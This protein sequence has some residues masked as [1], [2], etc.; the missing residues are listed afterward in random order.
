M[1]EFNNNEYR[2]KK[3]DI[4]D[5]T[6]EVHEEVKAHYESEGVGREYKRPVYD[7]SYNY[8]SANSSNASHGHER[9][10]KIKKPMSRGI[11]ALIIAILCFAS[12][13]GGA[14]VMGYVV[15]P[16]RETTYVTEDLNGNVSTAQAAQ[17]EESSS[18]AQ[19]SVSTAQAS[20][21]DNGANSVVNVAKTCTPGVVGIKTYAEQYVP[22]Q[23]VSENQISYGSGFVISQD[24]YIVTN[25]H[26]ISSGNKITVTL[27]DGTEYD[28]SVV[29]ADDDSDVAV[30]KIDAQGLTAL[31]IGD[32]DTVE[33]GQMVVAIGNPISEKLANTVTVGYVSGL[34]RQVS[35]EKRTYNVIQT[36]A[37]INSGNSG[38]PLVN[39]NG[40][41]IAVN[42]LKS[43]YAGTDG[44]GNLIESDGIGFAIPINYV[45][46]IA[47]QLMEN[48][49]IPKAGIGLTYYAMTAE[50]AQ[51]WNTP[52]GALVSA[53]TAGGSAQKAGLQANDIIIAVDGQQLSDDVTLGDLIGDKEI[54][55]SVTLTVY[56]S[57]ETL[58]LTV[59]IININEIR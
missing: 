2:Y 37:A 19:D 13:V 14:F 47:N 22:G 43:I 4:Q 42:T 11:F 9:A 39:T 59:D 52:Q 40:E 57:G 46:D 16:S 3:E 23:E 38:G 6:T 35:A 8:A 24:G 26:V 33:V 41:V 25:N 55:D 21:S 54:G 48:G 49:S 28:A 31:K 32:S 27:E 20:G 1:D 30:L 18:T 36:D 51:L 44:S 50:D 53:V 15:M 17:D 7:D 45:M 12:A 58:E 5:N 34:N 56:R 29:G 10:A